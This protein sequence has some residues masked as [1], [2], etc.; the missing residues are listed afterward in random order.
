M[1]FVYSSNLSVTGTIFKAQGTAETD[2]TL[3]GF[4]LRVSK[5]GWGFQAYWRVIIKYLSYKVKIRIGSIHHKKKVSVRTLYQVYTL[6]MLIVYGK[7]ET[8]FCENKL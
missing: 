6:N 2:S 5:T 3:E 8:L 7:M 1:D 4:V